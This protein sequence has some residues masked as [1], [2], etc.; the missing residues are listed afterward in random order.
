MDAITLS[1]AQMVN[2]SRL[3]ADTAWRAIIIATIANLTFKGGIVA[4][5]G[6]RVLLRRVA[7][8]FGINIMVGI[9]ILLFWP[10]AGDAA[11]NDPASQPAIEAAQGA[12]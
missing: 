5:M 2:N 6:G 11:A 3:E 7:L 4:V 8:L 10:T 9:G 1:T 12:P